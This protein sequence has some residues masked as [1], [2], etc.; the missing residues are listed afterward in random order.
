MGGEVLLIGGYQVC[1]G[2]LPINVAKKHCDLFVINFLT[3]QREDRGIPQRFGSK[4]NMEDK[5]DFELRQM[6]EGLDN[7][8]DLSSSSSSSSS[9][10]GDAV[11]KK[12][13]IAGE[14]GWTDQ[15]IASTY[16]TLKGVTAF[17]SR[18]PKFQT[19]LEWKNIDYKLQMPVPPQNFFLK[20]LLKLPFAD[21]LLMGKR[22]VQILHDISGVCKPGECLAIMGPTGSGKTTLL[23][24]LARRVKSGVTGQVLINGHKPTRRMKRQTAYVLQDDIFF[25]NLT[26]RETLNYTAYLKISHKLSF[27][28]KRERVEEAL[29]EMGLQRASNTIIGGHFVVS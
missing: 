4:A 1:S 8:E 21:Y 27:A 14:L 6:E 2:L 16:A 29:A 12:E 11:D 22:E 9:E 17:S 7:N 20:L 28:E 24:V 5:E 15:L 25:A 19:T 13:G 10:D 23:N 3:Q 26:V 18:E